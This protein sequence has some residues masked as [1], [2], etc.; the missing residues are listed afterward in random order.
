VTWRLGAAAALGVLCLLAGVARAQAPGGAPPEDRRGVDE[1]IA[2]GADPG[3]PPD[4]AEVPAAPEAAGPEAPEAGAAP[5]AG[6]AP[7]AGGAPEAAG[8]RGPLVPPGGVPPVG[9]RR[10]PA[11]PAPEP[12]PEPEPEPAVPPTYDVALHFRG[13]VAPESSFDRALRAHGYGS[14]S[15]VPVAYV[16]A[17][18]A[19]V[20]WLWL[21]GRVGMRGRIWGHADHDEATLFATDLLATA[22]VRLLLGRVVELGALVAGGVA[23]QTLRVGG[24]LSD[25]VTPRFG[26]EATLAFRIGNHFAIGPRAGWDYFQWEGMNAYDH[27]VELGGPYFGVALEGR[28]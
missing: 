4:R 8:P 19:L 15:V 2:P 20:E 12:E 5:G 18:G 27:G 22:Q 10:R 6:A 7:E 9:P 16:G 24:V 28:E 11:Q 21:G 3:T 13:A 25:Q 26:I 23:H 1:E 14:S 17:A